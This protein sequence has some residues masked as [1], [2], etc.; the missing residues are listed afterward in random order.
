M[1]VKKEKP[2]I[3]K[4]KT[5]IISFRICEKDFLLIQNFINKNHFNKSGVMRELTRTKLIPKIKRFN[6]N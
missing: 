2:K 4:S 3:K 6:K 5:K 1:R